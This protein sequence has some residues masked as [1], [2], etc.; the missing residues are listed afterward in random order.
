MHGINAPE[1]F[2][3]GVF[4]A[5]FATLKEESYIEAQGDEDIENTEKLANVLSGLLSTEIR[6]TI[7]ENLFVEPETTF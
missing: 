6:L 7:L 2:D 3:K 4:A 1:F 5:L